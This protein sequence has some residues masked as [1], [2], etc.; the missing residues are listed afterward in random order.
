MSLNIVM[1]A[2]FSF[3]VGWPIMMKGMENL[4]G[5]H[6]QCKFTSGLN[7]AIPVYCIHLRMMHPVRMLNTLEPII[8]VFFKKVE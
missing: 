7:T 1:F 5:M 3:T 2:L 4:Q 6:T 8:T